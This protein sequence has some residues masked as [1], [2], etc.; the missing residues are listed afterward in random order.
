MKLL[1][2]G[3]TEPRKL[4]SGPDLTPTRMVE[5]VTELC[6]DWEYDAVSIGYPGLVGTQ[7]PRA[8]PG[9]L[10]PGWVGFNFAA[11]FDCP[12][13]VLNDAAMQALGSY[14]GG[15]MLFVGLGTG[16]GSAFIAQHVIVPLELGRLPWRGK[17]ALA[18]TLGREGLERLGKRAWRKE[19]ARA[20][21]ILA[22]AFSVEYVVLGGGNAEHLR[23]VRTGTRVGHNMAAFRGGFRLW[24]LPDVSTL[25]AE[26]ESPVQQAPGEWRVI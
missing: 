18:K 7:G 22:H 11:A 3:Q 23:N 6:S 1:A 5:L 26:G 17:R 24:N 13:R 16:V 8:E 21:E 19:V 2:S 20:V 4:P 10:G 9:N 25:S 12:V 15:R 14:D